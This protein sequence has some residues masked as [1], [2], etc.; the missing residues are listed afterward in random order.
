MTQLMPDARTLTP[1]TT[2]IDAL[3]APMQDGGILIEP[4]ADRLMAAARANRSLRKLYKFK[5]LDRPADSWLADRTRDDAPLV[6]MSGHQPE[7]IHPGVW[8]KHVFGLRLADR[9]HGSMQFLVVDS[10]VPVVLRLE[11]PVV[12]GGFASI[13]SA[14]AD[15]VMNWRSYEYIHDRKEIDFAAIFAAVRKRFAGH[16]D[17][18][19]DAFASAMLAPQASGAYV[20]RWIAGLRQ[21]D[22]SLDVSPSQ[23]T[24]ISRSFGFSSA[25]H[26][27]AAAALVAHIIVNA[28]EF[29]T[30][31][32]DALDAYRQRR[33][34]A[35]VQ[36]PIP[37]LAE[38]QRRIETPFWLTHPERGRVRLY[39][40]PCKTADCVTLFAGDA[41]LAEI[42]VP[43]LIAS[44]ATALA[45]ALTDWGIRPRALAQTL[46]A[47]LF[48]CD[49][50]LHGI[51]GAKYDQIT[52]DIIRRFLNVEPP[53]FGCVSA[54]LRLDLPTYDAPADA[55]D[56]AEHQRRDLAYNPQRYL[57][58]AQSNVLADPLAER[59][60]AIAESDRL[61]EHDRAD[62]QARKAAFD[63]I[64]AANRRILDQLPE[65]TSA[66]ND[67]VAQLSREIAHNRIASNR[68]WFFALYTAGQLRE[69]RDKAWQA[70]DSAAQ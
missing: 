65:R 67:R 38:T 26:D 20:D 23:F 69:L 59:R 4:A 48:A 30:A 3:A 57:D 25:G 12:E 28:H 56:R 27:N 21:C 60:A 2:A 45:G 18:P 19:L 42:Q 11:W 37:D 10:D 46:Y 49:L 44:P 17:T 52:D 39:A 24:R 5:L 54:T 62:R 6:I 41:P 8:I 36:H 9:L 13:D 29:R 43:D 1:A 64:Q 40:T 34:I 51:G 68:E 55:L 22:A 33:N 63:R 61:R 14:R 7:F 66:L 50:F 15:A 16:G 32:N 58:E 47:R 31:Y 53:A 35:G 70:V